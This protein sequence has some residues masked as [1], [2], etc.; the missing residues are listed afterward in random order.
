MATDDVAHEVLSRL[1]ENGTTPMWPA[2]AR[3]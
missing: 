1:T 3:R 2:T